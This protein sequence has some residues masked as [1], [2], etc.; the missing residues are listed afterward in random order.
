MNNFIL[1][2]RLVTVIRKREGLLTAEGIG[3]LPNLPCMYHGASY[4]GPWGHR[5]TQLGHSASPL[6][7]VPR[8]TGER[9]QQSRSLRERGQPRMLRGALW[10][11]L[12]TVLR[13]SRNE[14]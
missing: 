2:I 12:P 7:E 4:K 10:R 3:D 9:P 1:A 13:L 5:E 8:K 14:G 6:G 11:V